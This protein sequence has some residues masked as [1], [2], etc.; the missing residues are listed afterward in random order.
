MR[1]L[2]IAFVML[3]LVLMCSAFTM[4][5]S[6]GVYI[7]GVSASF[8]DSLIFFTEVQ[9]LDSVELSKDKMLPYRSEYSR[10]LDDYLEKIK[11]LENRTSF[12]YFGTDKSKLE[13]NLKKM[14]NK[15]DESG[16]SIIRELGSEFKFTK[17]KF[18]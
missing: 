2:N 9:L 13:K 10:Q 18:E 17:P 15:Y 14:K 11:G 12:V 5:G 4:K 8:S 1:K 3:M 16:K 6:K 7:A